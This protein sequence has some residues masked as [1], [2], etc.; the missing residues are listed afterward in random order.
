MRPCLFVLLAVLVAL[1]GCKSDPK[2]QVVGK[3]KFDVDS[4]QMP[5]LTAE[6]KKSSGFK[7]GFKEME[8]ARLE[9][10]ADGTYAGTGMGPNGSG[11]WTLD[12]RTIKITE[13]KAKDATLPTLT[14]SE[15]GSKIKMSQASPMGQG[16]MTMDLVKA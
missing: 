3:W 13:D 16:E 1:S 10:K 2:S 15:D 14:L 9:F 4:L 5:G 6:M 8:T 11:K 12:G 7:A